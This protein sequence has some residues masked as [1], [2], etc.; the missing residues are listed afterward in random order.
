MPDE[1]GHEMPAGTARSIIETLRS[2]GVDPVVGGGW[3]VDA[4]LC[5]QTRPH[6]DL[7]LWLPADRYENLVQAAAAI[8]LDRLYPWGD[9]RP[10][11][12]VLHDG[13][14]RRLDLHIYEP[15]D[16]PTLHYGSVVG[17]ETFPVD[18][19]SGTGVIDEAPVV[20]ESP[21]WA[22]HWHTGYPLRAVDRHDVER[23]CKRFGI[24][25]PHEY[26]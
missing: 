12:F 25:L 13:A 4:L 8:G 11:N 15:I 19:L 10:W 5:Q 16:G 18:A 7:D 24:D 9:D 21:E 20:C 17:G 6:S 26:R 14:M 1:H 22:V 2:A 23:L 3:A